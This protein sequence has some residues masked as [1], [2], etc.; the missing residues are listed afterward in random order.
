MPSS[1]IAVQLYTLRD[2][3]KT[4]ADI[5]RTFARVK[6]LGYDAVQ[7]SAL[8]PIEPA[9]LAK[10][11]RNEGLAC[12]ATHIGMDA[13][14][15]QTQQVIDNHALWGC[16]W[17]AI[18]GWGW[19][20]ADAAAWKQFALD[21]SAI[22]AKFKGSGLSIGYHNHSHE[23]VK[24]AGSPD[25]ALDIILKNASSDVWFEIDTYWITHGGGDPAAWI[26]KVAGRI[27][28]VH[29]KDMGI[30]HE[31]HQKMREV[32]EGNLNWPRIIE[33][34]RKAGVQWYI[35]EQDDCDGADPFECVE[36]SLKN[37]KA[38]GVS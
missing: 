21:Y 38:L 23:L 37:L 17:T 4:P 1:Q 29:F 30:T 25:T 15:D 3:T 19:K 13:M 7:C 24:F 31:R 5:A 27:P 26:D 18:G 34:C 14:R 8:G 2:F 22:A 6:K 33:S 28:C 16:H 36:R 12:A 9:E 32:G 20:D 35:V 11:L 10:I